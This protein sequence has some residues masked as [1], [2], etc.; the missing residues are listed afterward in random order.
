MN[1][2]FREEEIYK[3]KELCVKLGEC[4]T[5]Y[6]LVFL[7]DEVERLLLEERK[8]KDL[9]IMIRRLVAHLNKISPHDAIASQAMILLTKH[10]LQGEIIREQP[11]SP[12]QPKTIGPL[13]SCKTCKWECKVEGETSHR[14]NYCMANGLCDWEPKEGGEL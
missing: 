5:S 1:S 9:G 6:Y 3:A 4:I 8:M 12:A 2:G 14:N 11:A 7:I 13:L 10:S